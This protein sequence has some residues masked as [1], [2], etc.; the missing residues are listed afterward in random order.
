MA[1]DFTFIQ[2]SQL[3]LDAELKKNRE[4]Q[5]PLRK[6]LRNTFKEI[7]SITAREKPDALLICGNLFATPQP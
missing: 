2:T 5:E 1:S 7:I 4:I 3:R 6:A